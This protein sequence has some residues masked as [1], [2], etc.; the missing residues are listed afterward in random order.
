MSDP[1][2]E[3]DAAADVEEVLGAQQG[4]FGLLS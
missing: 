1:A 2:P 4:D 3:A